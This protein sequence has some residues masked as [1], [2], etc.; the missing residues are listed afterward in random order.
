MLSKGKKLGPQDLGALAALGWVQV[1]VASAI[2]VG[3]ISTGDELVPV[4]DVYK[5]QV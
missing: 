3:V 1:P 2:R 5:R 4:E